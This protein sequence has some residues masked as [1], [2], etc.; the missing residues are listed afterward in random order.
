MKL[1]KYIEMV[2]IAGIIFFLAACQTA[3]PGTDTAVPQAS[4]TPQPGPVARALISEVLGGVQG[5]NDHDFIELYNPSPDTPLNLD[6]MTLWYQ[7]EEGKEERILYRWTETAYL[8]PHGHYLLGRLGQTYAAEVDAFFDLSLATSRGGLL[9]RGADDQP[10]DSLSWG[11]D[12]QKYGEGEAAPATTRGVSLERKPGGEQGHSTDTDDNSSDFSLQEDPWPQGTASRVTPFREERLEIKVSAPE[13]VKPGERF[14]YQVEVTNHTGQKLHGVQTV[15]PLPRELSAEQDGTL[16]VEQAGSLVWTIDQLERGESSQAELNLQAPWTYLDARLIN[17]FVEAEDWPVPAFG[18]PVQTSVAGGSIPIDRARTLMGKEVVLEGVATMYTGGYY[19]GTGNVKFYLEDE[20]AGIQVWVPEGEGPVK[21]EIGD[22]VR[23]KG[24]PEMYR[25]AVELVVED[26]EE[27]VVIREESATPPAPSPVSIAEVI[28]GDEDLPGRL[29]ELEGMITRVEEFTYSYEIDL[30]DEFGQ[31]LTLYV[32]KQTSLNVERLEEGDH[33]QAAGILEVRDGKIQLY[34][35]VQQDLVKVYPPVLRLTLQAPNT[36]KVGEEFPVSLT[37]YNHTAEEMTGVEIYLNVPDNALVAEVEDQEQQVE[38]GQLRW[39]VGS[40]AGGGSE[41]TVNCKL[42][43]T[44]G[45]YLTF[46]ESWAVSDQWTDPA[47]IDLKYVFGGER[48]PVWAVQGPG[49]RSPY[50]LEEIQT[51]GVVTG[52]FPELDGFWIQEIETDLDPLT[53][54]GLFINTEGL[55]VNVNRG[56]VV[57]IQG[58]ARESY[59]QTQLKVDSVSD[60]EVIGSGRLLPQPVELDPPASDVEAEGYF[61]ALEG[62]LV[63]VTSPGMAVSP[64]TKYGEFTFVLAKHGVQR[65]WQREN[66]GWGIMVD[67]GSNVEHEYRTTLPYV[68]TVGDRVTDLAGPLAYTYGQYKMEPVKEPRVTPADREL[69]ALAQVPVDEFTLATWNVENLFD[70]MLPH[71]S[72]PGLPTAGEYEID[73]KKVANTLVAAG[74]PTVVGFQEVENQDILEDL[75]AEEALRAYQ[76]QPLL[77]E[78]TDSRGIDVGYLVRG[79]QA[80]VLEVEQY[81]APEGLTSRPPLMVRLGFGEGD[82]AQQVIVLNNH[83]TSMSG[84]EEATEPRR[85]AQAAWN[86]EVLEGLREEYP[87]A[88]FAV[89]GDL[90]SYFDSPPIHT[91]RDAGLE[92]VMDQLSE[93]TRYTYIYQGRSQVLDHIL[94]DAGMME[95]MVGV[96]VLHTNADFP[97]PLPED[98]SPLRKSDHDLLRATFR[99]QE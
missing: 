4:S 65:L 52:V 62:S 57:E 45:E 21:V 61:E 43:A 92:H 98:V 23:V 58:V 70:I 36:A 11:D 71:P 79:D 51:G 34:P 25:G 17:Y 69:P 80:R 40:L 81:P 50:I 14:R 84:G 48:I 83:F 42:R 55:Q 47:L 37:A 91:L 13:T 88:L 2:F 59:Q 56:D 24:I 15:L 28:A 86:V 64:S 95:Q 26:L 3:E 18:G 12:P 85:T 41:V 60:V 74:A 97:L 10:V 31:T 20:T 63:Q 44:G 93:Q 38:G 46:K 49:F 7:L 16:W 32:D 29:V 19:A 77:L 94:V 6:G 76:Y 27:G 53:S 68:V 90:N 96:Q 5:N 9:L 22:R 72:D 1:V 75:V 73:L 67:D 8:P 78:G 35:R 39:Q 82:D 99:F 89:I 87:E 33:Y 66:S 30:Q 54:P